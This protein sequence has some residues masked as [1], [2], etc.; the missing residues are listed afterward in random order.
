[1]AFDIARP[2]EV[3]TECCYVFYDFRQIIIELMPLASNL[4]ELSMGKF[5]FIK[6]DVKKGH[7]LI[8]GTMIKEYR[9]MRNFLSSKLIVHIKALKFPAARS[10]KRR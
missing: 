3:S 10:P 5:C 6:C 7:D 4:P 1:M 2:S 8:V 9:C